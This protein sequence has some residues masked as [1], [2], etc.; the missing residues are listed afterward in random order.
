MK[1]RL[2]AS[3]VSLF[4]SALA[5]EPRDTMP[6][7]RAATDALGR[8][9]PM[10]EEVGTPKPNRTVGLFYFNWHAAFGNP[11]VHDIAKILAANPIEPPWGPVRSHLNTD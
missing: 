4:A 3:L 5:G 10:H 1:I 9:L 8:V 11:A 7:T 6:D 2:L